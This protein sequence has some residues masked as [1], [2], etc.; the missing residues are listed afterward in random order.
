[1]YYMNIMEVCYLLPFFSLKEFLIQKFIHVEPLYFL[2]SSSEI[3]TTV[4]LWMRQN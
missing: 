1:M 2:L 3:E 4:V